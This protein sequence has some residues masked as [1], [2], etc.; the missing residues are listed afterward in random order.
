[1]DQKGGRVQNEKAKEPAV[2]ILSNTDTRW[3]AISI[4][5]FPTLFEL[6]GF[7]HFRNF[8]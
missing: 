3:G 6:G 1:M 4:N 8:N 2:I 7:S 5:L